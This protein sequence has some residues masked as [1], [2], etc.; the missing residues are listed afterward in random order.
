MS[1]SAR[2]T[3]CRC[4]RLISVRSNGLSELS[5]QTVRT[6]KAIQK[7]GDYVRTHSDLVRA[8]YA[9]NVGVCLTNQQMRAFCT[10]LRTLP[11]ACGAWFIESR[12]VRP[13]RSK[14]SAC[15]V[16]PAE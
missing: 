8:F 2:H 15:S 12:G 1:S 5:T 16:K 3:D 14:L 10:N 7:A 6:S 9:S 13:L 4:H 11:A